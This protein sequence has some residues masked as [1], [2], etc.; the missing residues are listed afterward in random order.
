VVVLVVKQVVERRLRF[1]A[2]A[3]PRAHRFDCP[4]EAEVKGEEVAISYGT[5]DH[6]WQL[7]AVHAG[8]IAIWIQGRRNGGKGLQLSRGEQASAY[9][10]LAGWGELVAELAAVVRQEVLQ[11]ANL[12]VASEGSNV[13]TRNR[14]DTCLA[15]AGRVVL[16]D[17]FQIAWCKEG[18]SLRKGR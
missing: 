1:D 9:K 14:G 2:E 4:T 3:F 16:E 13:R 12:D 10:G 11:V 6:A 15:I 5:G 7:Q 8:A 18:Q 17:V